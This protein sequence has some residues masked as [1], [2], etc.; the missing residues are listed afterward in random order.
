MSD[1]AA[2]FVQMSHP[3]SHR[4]FKVERRGRSIVIGYEPHQEIVQCVSVA[5]AREEL[6]QRVRV[7]V[8][9]GF[10]DVRAKYAAPEPPPPPPRDLRRLMRSG[11]RLGDLTIEVRRLGRLDVGDGKL[12][13]CDP[14]GPPRRAFV[15]AVPRGVFPV[16]AA[17][18]GFPITRSRTKWKEDLRCAAAW[19]RFARRKIERFVPAKLG[20][21]STSSFGVDAGTAAFVG[22]RGAARADVAEVDALTAQLLT[23]GR[24]P[25][26][27]WATLPEGTGPK[28]TIAFSSG[29][30]DGAYPCH[31]GLD[32]QGKVV[33]AFVDFGIVDDARWVAPSPVR[34]RRRTPPSATRRAT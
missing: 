18:V 11:E 8:R 30:G 1:D 4:L 29:F 32:A 3:R 23:K 25:S 14:L 5:A 31:F 21:G 27:A 9:R 34:A 22:G 7:Q 33:C 17:I 15:A 19:V 2:D 16:E 28:G 26:F 12:V 20:R 6:A 13:A 10:V 24:P